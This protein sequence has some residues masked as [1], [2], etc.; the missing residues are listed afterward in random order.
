LTLP[1]HCQA[2]APKR[3]KAVQTRLGEFHDEAG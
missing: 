3:H 2:A 1:K